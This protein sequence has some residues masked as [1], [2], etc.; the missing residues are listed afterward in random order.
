MFGRTKNAFQILGVDENCTDEQ[1]KDA[2]MRLAKQWHPDLNKSTDS[3]KK[4]QTISHAFDQV[5][6]E[7]ARM[8]YRSQLQALQYGS[9][10]KQWRT[11]ASDMNSDANFR[12]DYNKAWAKQTR[13]RWRNIGLFVFMPTM[14]VVVGIALFSGQRKSADVSGES[15]GAWNSRAQKGASLVDAWYNSRTRRWETPAPW[16]PHY[17]EF[18]SK[19]SLKQIDKRMVYDS[20]KTR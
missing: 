6:S 16:D 4:F 11:R 5:K 9:M 17:K 7:T 1:V 15:M 12:K 20:S 8:H 10:V 2:Y 13:A 19:S 18:V 14:A 3:T